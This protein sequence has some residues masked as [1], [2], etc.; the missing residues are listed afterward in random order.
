MLY[1]AAIRRSVDA[2]RR[3]FPF[4]LIHAHFTYPDGVV[5]TR[6]GQRYRVPVIVTEHIPWDVWVGKYPKVLR[7][8]TQTVGQCAYHI[9]VSQS[10]RRTVEQ[11][12]G[13]RENLVVV[14]NGV[15]GSLFAPAGSGPRRIRNQL[16]FAG[17]VRPIKGVDLLLRSLRLLADRGYDARLLLVGEAFYGSYKKEEVRLQQMTRDLGLQDRVNFAGKKS[18]SELAAHMRESALLVLPSRAESFGMVLVEALACGTP[19][20]AT[21][22]GGPEDIV[23]SQVGVLVPPEDPAALAQ[24][25]RHVLDHGANY[26]PA[27]LRAHAVENFGL[28][29]VGNRIAQLYRE[30]V[31]SFH[32]QSGANVAEGASLAG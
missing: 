27:R 14:P 5:A 30:A 26:D 15:D 2:L 29:P 7:R 3:E 18:P 9:S 23:T 12:T 6:L 32:G 22:C 19:V 13:T 24:G 21:R 4:D 17:A 1:Y 16:L 31:R 20:V 28:E 8:A 10:V 25:I 11:C